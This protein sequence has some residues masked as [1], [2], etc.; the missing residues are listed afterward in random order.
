[1]THFRLLAV[2]TTEKPVEASPLFCATTAVLK[3]AL[4]PST[5]ADKL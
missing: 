4:V 2:I 3:A 1:M 5:L